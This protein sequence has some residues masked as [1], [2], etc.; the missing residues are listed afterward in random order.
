[1]PGRSDWAAQVAGLGSQQLRKDL[2]GL[3]G[4]RLGVLQV[5]VGTPVE[6]SDIGDALNIEVQSYCAVRVYGFGV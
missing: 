1:M 4:L 6:G 2:R 3:G 5:R